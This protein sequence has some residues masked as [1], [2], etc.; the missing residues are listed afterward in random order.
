MKNFQII[1]HLIL[2][3]KLALLIEFEVNFKNLIVTLV[4]IIF[5]NKRVVSY[6]DDQSSKFHI[7]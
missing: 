1:D 7:D 6:V 5:N 2:I 4:T 3:T